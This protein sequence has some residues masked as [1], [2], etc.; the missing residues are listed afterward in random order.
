MQFCKKIFV[1]NAIQNTVFKA[2]IFNT[3]FLLQKIGADGLTLFQKRLQSKIA[4]FNYCIFCFL[5]ISNQNNLI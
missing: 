1:I 3:H 2:H 5:I 4:V